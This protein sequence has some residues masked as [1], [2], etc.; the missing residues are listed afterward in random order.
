MKKIILL[1]LAFA[2]VLPLAEA[3]K[4]HHKKE[5]NPAAKQELKAHF[6]NNVR[7]VMNEALKE[8][9]AKLSK[10]DLEFVQAKRK[11]IRSLKETQ[12]AQFEKMKSV[13]QSKEELSDEEMGNMIAAKINAK[14][15]MRDFHES[16]KPFMERNKELIQSS[17]EDLKPQYESWGA[18]KKEIFKKYRP[19]GEKGKKRGACC[20]EGGEKSCE[21]KCEGKGKMKKGKD[22]G[23]KM[24]G[25]RGRRHHMKGKRG[26]MGRRGHKGKKDHTLRFVLWDGKGMDEGAL[27]RN[28]DELLPALDQNYPNPAANFTTIEFELP[29][30]AKLVKISIADV[31][32]KEVKFLNLGALNA[33]KHI[34]KIDLTDIQTGNYFYTIDTDGAKVTKKMVVTK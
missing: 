14:N 5:M 7:P 31:N 20:K 4:R 11:E 16:M 6:E 13:H 17:M 19:E 10:S 34:Q 23:E 32:G 3:Q 26:E 15:T 30:N 21:G 2:M 12:R 9:D 27:N 33:G 1:V 25:H 8:F 18:A 28:S 24:E 29:T 22:K